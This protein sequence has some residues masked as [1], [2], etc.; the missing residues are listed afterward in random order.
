[1]EEME[2]KTIKDLAVTLSQGIG[3]YVVVNLK[4]TNLDAEIPANLPYGISE[5]IDEEPRAL[6]FEQGEDDARDAYREIC[7][8]LEEYRDHLTGAITLAEEGEEED[9]MEIG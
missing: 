7:D 9:E 2:V 6:E 4:R 3:S 8:A 1:M 5:F